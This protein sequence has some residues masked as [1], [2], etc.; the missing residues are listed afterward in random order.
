[1]KTTLYDQ[2][3]HIQ[4]QHPTKVCLRDAK[5]DWTFSDLLDKTNRHAEALTQEGLGLGDRLLYIAGRGVNTLP[6]LLAASKLGVLFATIDARADQTKNQAIIDQFE[7]DILLIAPEHASKAMYQLSYYRELGCTVNSNADN[8][9]ADTS[10]TEQRHA[11]G[12][13]G[14]LR[15]DRATGVCDTAVATQPRSRKPVASDIGLVFF[16]SGSTG[17]SKGVA[18]SHSNVLFAAQSIIE[19]LEI[20]ADDVIYNALPLNFD[21]GFYQILFPLF[22]GCQTFLT[23]SFMI[24]Q[25]NLMEVQKINATHFPI[26]PSMARLIKQFG[27]AKALES[28]TTITNTGEAIHRGEVEYMQ[29]IFPHCRF[30]SMYGLTECKRT[31]WLHPDEY[32]KKPDSVGIAIPGTRIEILDENNQPVPAGTEGQ[33]VV[34]GPH[35]M[36]EYLD[37]PEATRKAL[38]FDEND[39]QKKLATG[40]FGRM[41]SEGYLYLSG[42]KDEVFKID[43]L[44]YSCKEHEQWLKSQPEVRD[45]CILVNPDTLEITAFIVEEIGERMTEGMIRERRLKTCALSS[46]LPKHVERLTDI[47]INDNGKHNKQR[48]KQ[49]LQQGD[50]AQWQL[51]DS[52]TH[53]QPRQLAETL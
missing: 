28:V 5:N 1:M 11:F 25:K 32:A 37:N 21:Y 13:P 12:A 33:I 53:V 46:H 23:H 24:P 19:Y 14:W 52:L 7:A 42:R 45:A 51:P 27:A 29:N 36:T 6:L 48:L 44:K 17:R 10:N 8:S 22:T 38:F 49:G 34:S 16:T 31:T 26:V 20:D 9:N 4:Q 2:L 18:L 30:F 41:D 50:L 35:V 3:L 40:D 15:N 43:G 47:P 39:R